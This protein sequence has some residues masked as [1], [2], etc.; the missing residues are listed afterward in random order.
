MAKNFDPW[1]ASNY[2]TSMLRDA[3]QNMRD[4]MSKI[5]LPGEK[6]S[7]GDELLGAAITGLAIAAD[8][9]D[10]LHQ[11]NRPDIQTVATATD[12]DGGVYLFGVD[13]V[14]HVWQYAFN[15]NR[16]LE[17]WVGLNGAHAKMG[18]PT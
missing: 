6:K 2:D 14:G 12:D 18:E 17:G 11:S 9:I 13:S 1:V 7:E 10:R 5:V 16:Q 15:D 4:N 8:R 3:A